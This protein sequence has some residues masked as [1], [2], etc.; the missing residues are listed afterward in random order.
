MIYT[1]VYKYLLY[2]QTMRITYYSYKNFDV[3]QIDRAVSNVYA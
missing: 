2:L 1:Y 3:Y